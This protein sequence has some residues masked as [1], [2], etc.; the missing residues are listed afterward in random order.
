[1]DQ[2][3]GIS[4]L[5][6]G[7]LLL[8][9]YLQSSPA[10]E[11]ARRALYLLIDR[12]LS[13][14][15]PTGE[16]NLAERLETLSEQGV[17]APEAKAKLLSLH[18]E[19]L[20][21]FAADSRYVPGFIQK[22]VAAFVAAVN[23][24]YRGSGGRDLESEL[25]KLSPESWARVEKAAG[26]AVAL[27][28]QAMDTMSI[29]PEDFRDLSLLRSKVQ[30]WAPALLPALR[31]K[32]FAFT[33]DSISRVNLSSGYIWVAFLPDPSRRK[34]EQ[35]TYSFSFTP[36]H[37]RA[38]LELGGKTR[39]ARAAY[40]KK[41]L[42]GELDDIIAAMAPLGGVFLDVVWYFSARD[43]VSMRDY[44]ADQDGAKKR[45][46]A[47]IADGR[48]RLPRDVLYTWNLL[49]PVVLITPEEFAREGINDFLVRLADP[50]VKLIRRIGG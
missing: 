9:R 47:K 7:A 13:P 25:G 45:V 2:E 15:S 16:K 35:P 46:A 39:E 11:A 43:A 22:R 23:G 31:E 49:L 6:L 21:F 33:L 32:G 48:K 14:A 36:R 8:S 4:D 34:M 28:R 20:S 24:F 5:L 38:G 37:C 19:L 3:C 27:V 41:L 26:T 18:R 44:L 40:Y 10:G 17:L 1:M 12:S 29:R 30:V 50:V 42:S